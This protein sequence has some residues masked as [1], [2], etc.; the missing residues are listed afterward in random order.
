MCVCVCVWRGYNEITHSGLIAATPGGRD[1]P[2]LSSHAAP[3][4][5]ESSVARLAMS[6]VRYNCDPDC[7]Q[8]GEEA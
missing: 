4:D 8:R 7:K 2:T 6:N 1:E 5:R 3:D